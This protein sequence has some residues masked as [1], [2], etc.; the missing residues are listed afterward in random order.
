MLAG[1]WKNVSR[2]HPGLFHGVMRENRQQP[3][4]ATEIV[5]AIQ[6]DTK[7][8]THK[9]RKGQMARLT[10][11]LLNRLLSQLGHNVRPSEDVWLEAV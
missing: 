9:S 4:P 10:F 1:G 11:W 6:A 8:A 7:I 5:E 2:Q 3:Q